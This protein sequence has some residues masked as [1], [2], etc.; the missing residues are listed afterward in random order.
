MTALLDIGEVVAR[1]GVPVTTLHVWERQG[2]ISPAGRV[3][4]R[5]QYDPG[6]LRILAIIVVCQ[7]AGFRL[8]E[9]RAI[10]RPGAFADGK[11]LFETKLAELEDQRRVLDQAIDGIRHA[12]ACTH[13]SPLDCPDFG[14]ILE[15]VLPVRS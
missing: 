1:S 8:S 6:V 4:L 5:R 12:I 3:G 14:T 2:L 10:L 15:S 11:N 9:I 13:P 7:G